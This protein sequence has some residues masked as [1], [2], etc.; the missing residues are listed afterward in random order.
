MEQ[1]R[2]D[3][4]FFSARP[5][6]KQIPSNDSTLICPNPR[7]NRRN[8]GA[9]LTCLNDARNRRSVTGDRGQNGDSRRF[10]L[11]FAADSRCAPP[12][13]ARAYS[14]FLGAFDALLPVPAAVRFV[15]VGARFAAGRL[16]ADSALPLDPPDA[17]AAAA[18]SAGDGR[19]TSVAPPTA[20]L[21]SSRWS[22]VDAA[23]APPLVAAPAAP[24]APAAGCVIANW[25]I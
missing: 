10:L 22:S 20:S 8:S 9:R 5:K 11:L 12:S 1:G 19:G 14:D 3:W 6:A 25:A 2:L 7:G 18:T 16:A 21:A 4:L 15:A 17:A 23:C 24:A 13:G